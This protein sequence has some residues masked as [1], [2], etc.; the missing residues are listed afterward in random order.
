MP[1]KLRVNFF[2]PVIAAIL[3]FL[4]LIMIFVPAGPAAGVT[5][6]F[7]PGD[8]TG[9]GIVDVRDVTILMRYSL[10]LI[11]SFN[12][13]FRLGSEVLLSEERHLVEGRKVGLVTNQSGVNSR[14]ESTKELFFAAEDIDLKVLYAP[15]HGLDG[16]AAA[17]E[18]VKSYTHED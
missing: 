10:G 7:V 12:E 1:G 14:G 17:G 6:E 4:A 18:Y 16:K 2:N 13:S 15:E 5:Q 11:D 8:V 3:A 9:D